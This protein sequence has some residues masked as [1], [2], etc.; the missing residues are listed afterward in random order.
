MISS[1]AASKESVV[2]KDDRSSSRLQSSHE[3]TAY[4]WNGASRF[5]VWGNRVTPFASLGYAA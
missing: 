1:A 2:T 4:I 5:A 3:L